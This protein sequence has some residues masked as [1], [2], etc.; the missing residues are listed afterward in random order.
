MVRKIIDNSLNKSREGR[1]L[2][3]MKTRRGSTW[4]WHDMVVMTITWPGSTQ[5]LT[6]HPSLLHHHVNEQIKETEKLTLHS[7]CG[8]TRKDDREDMAMVSAWWKGC[9]IFMLSMQMGDGGPTANELF[10]RSNKVIKYVGINIR[11]H[12]MYAF[13][14]LP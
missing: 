1:T 14:N 9:N 12:S 10:V 13:S 6:W 5:Q 4:Q 7:L 3:K 8:R 2:E 11:L